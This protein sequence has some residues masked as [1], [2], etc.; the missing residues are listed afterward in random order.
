MY[1][2][3]NPASASARGLLSFVLSVVRV[4]AQFSTLKQL[5]QTM[6]VQAVMRLICVRKHP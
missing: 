4:M 1:S 5:R 6:A 3:S 2:D